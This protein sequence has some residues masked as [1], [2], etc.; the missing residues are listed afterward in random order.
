MGWGSGA[1]GLG[2]GL[3]WNFFGVRR[4]YWVR[5]QH[6]AERMDAGTLPLRRVHGILMKKPGLHCAAHAASQPASPP[7]TRHQTRV[8]HHNALVLEHKV[9]PHTSL[10]HFLCHSHP[11][12]PRPQLDCALFFTMSYAAKPSQPKRPGCASSVPRNTNGQSL[13]SFGLLW[14]LLTVWH[15][16][17]SA[18]SL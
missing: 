2:L 16:A 10:C 3:G 6:S 9:H 1:C 11:S 17:S 8:R 14:W 4:A 5:A 18:W 15:E 13:L 7:G 12:S